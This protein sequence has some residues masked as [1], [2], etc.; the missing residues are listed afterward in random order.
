VIVGAGAPDVVADELVEDW[1]VG[2]DGLVGD[3]IEVERGGCT[4]G[5]MVEGVC[6]GEEVD[7]TEV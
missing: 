7:G 1:D 5:E 4:L 2:E 6:V 3:D